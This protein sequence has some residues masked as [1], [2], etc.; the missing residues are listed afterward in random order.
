MEPQWNTSS[1]N[2]PRIDASELV[3]KE[4]PVTIIATLRESDTSILI[5]ADSGG[6]E[7]PPGIRIQ[8]PI[9]LRKHTTAPLAWGYTGNPTIGD[10]FTDWLRDYEWPPTSWRTFRDDAIRYLATLNGKQRE[11]VELSRA[12]PGEGDT[13]Q[14]LLAGWLDRPEILEL[15][16]RGLATSYSDDQFQ[17]VGAGKP[18]ALIAYWV[19]EGVIP[20]PLEKM[21]LIMA[22]ASQM[23]PKC[24]PPVNIWRVT[25]EG[26]TDIL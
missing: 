15:N 13:A 16:D 23:T 14:I 21:K 4:P 5:A 19:L 10:D 26:I 25:A 12:K 2:Y 11:L 24:D 3:L 9:K 17:A 7:E 22:V 18:V 6:V 20:S 1:G 8:F